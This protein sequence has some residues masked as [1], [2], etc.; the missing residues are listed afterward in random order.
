MTA[1]YRVRAPIHGALTS[2]VITF[3]PCSALR[4]WYWM[5]FSLLVVA[6]KSLTNTV[7]SSARL[8]ANWQCCCAWRIA[9]YQAT[10]MA[11]RFAHS[12]ATWLH[13]SAHHMYIDSFFS[14]PRAHRCTRL[15]IFVWL[16]WAY[17]M[18]DLIA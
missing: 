11:R 14:G 13:S 7:T 2:S 12:R 1:I 6:K 10:K 17:W 16:S 18:T 5:R 3:D 15:L 4:A 8:G 9:R